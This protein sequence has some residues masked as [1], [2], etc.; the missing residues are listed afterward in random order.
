MGWN[1]RNEL[2]HG[3]VDEVSGPAAALLVQAALFIAMLTPRAEEDSG[4]DAQE[5]PT[6]SQ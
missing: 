4:P 3:F 6:P 5:E 2:A 1:F